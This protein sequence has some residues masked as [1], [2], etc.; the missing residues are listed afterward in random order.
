[1]P[2]TRSTIL[3]AILFGLVWTLAPGTHGAWA[4]SDHRWLSAQL[5]WENDTLSGTDEHYTN[6]VRFSWIRNPGVRDNPTWTRRLA[7][8]WCFE[9][10]L[11]V[12][13]SPALV[14]YGHAIGQSL[15]TPED[16]TV[17]S[18]ILDDRPY[19]AY[20]YGAWVVAF[21][22]DTAAT[23]EDTRPIQNQFELQ[24]GTVGPPALGEEVQSAVH[25]LID[26]DEPRGWDH[27]IDFEPTI[28]LLYRWRRK[29]GSTRL[30]FV[31]HVGVGLGNVMTFA[32]VGGTVR[33]G[34]NISDFPV[35]PVVPTAAP[36]GPPPPEWEFYVFA[37]AEGRGVARN[38]FLDG[39]T[40]EDSHS[41]DREPFVHDLTAGA[42]VRW[43]DWRLTYTFVRR[44]GEFEGGPG[45]EDHD[46]ASVGLT[47]LAWSGS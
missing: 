30:D 28:E 35:S 46:F 16:I 45:E 21:R 38:I 44:S 33:L 18:L 37:G 20:L 22:N 23:F 9:T 14:T 24:V 43:R 15:Y 42:S 31:P 26:S 17:P 19:A 11:C 41:V 12:V 36:T 6:G 47:Y 27:Q 32:A 13:D 34:Y 29:L 10:P 39:N 25:E 8:W 7:E 2:P 5:Q 1:M 40:F 4:Q 3:A